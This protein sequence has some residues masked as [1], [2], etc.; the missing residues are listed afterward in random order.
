MARSPE[1][2]PTQEQVSGTLAS[3]LLRGL[4][5][6]RGISAI[7]AGLGV[8]ALVIGVVLLALS[9]ELDGTAYTSMI[10]GLILLLVALLTSLEPVLHAITGK[11][12]RYG[13]NTA[14]MV[15]AF[16]ALILSA[17]VLAF[18]NPERFDITATKQFS[19]ADQTLKLLRELEEPVQ[20]MAFFPPGD[21]SSEPF[22]QPAED[23]LDEFKRRSG[24]KF[25]YEFIDPDREPTTARLFGITQY[26][27]IAFVGATSNRL[28]HVLAPQIQE[29]GFATAIL[30]ATGKEQ[31][32]LYFL[33][34]HG[35]RDPEDFD[36]G[37]EGFGLAID[38]LFA[39]N[40]AIA[41]RSLIET[42]EIP[43]L[44]NVERLGLNRSAAAAAVVIAGPTR[45]LEESESEDLFTYLKGGGRAIFLLDPDP[46]QSFKDLLARWGIKV[47]DG[48]II[49]RG[50]S[51]SD[52]PQ[53]PLLHRS[54][55]TDAAS[56]SSITTSLDENFF[57][58]TTGFDY[59][60]LYD[61]PGY[62]T[63]FD[64]EQDPPPDGITF[65][66]LASTT[67]L[68]CTTND[69]DSDQCDETAGFGLLVPALA[70]TADRP[71]DGEPDPNAPRNTGI[72]LFGDSDFTTNK[73]LYSRSNNDFFL[74]SVNW[75]T[76]DISLSSAR[77]KP[78]VFRQLV[79]TQPEL[80]F[81]RYSSWLL[82]PIGISLLGAVAWWR[83]R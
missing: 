53:T 51:V 58:G 42:P 11:R 27:T 48:L 35:E 25:D 49:D 41:P 12:G 20:A 23:L 81:I 6:G 55:Y 68:G 70:V 33:T 62:Q 2:D 30:I 38:A 66:P 60:G 9:E 80:R 18:R 50:S 79:L 57:P 39:D 74:N 69:L 52:Q 44:E 19:L 83:R 56:I 16:G 32:L 76:E 67:L 64:P 61:L 21:F 40:Y 10:A 22:R 59:P 65:I 47:N 7:A 75:L 15:V 71:V 1:E 43:T 28:S 3:N 4:S 29:R 54:Q 82:L 24:G 72:V 46:P 73:Y 8:I 45:D 37:T 26:P 14:I 36:P 77:P 13:T 31:K 34:G 63:S 5:R 17:D 78:L